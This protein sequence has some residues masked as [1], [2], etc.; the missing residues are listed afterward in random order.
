MHSTNNKQFGVPVS[1]LLHSENK[2]ANNK[3]KTYETQCSLLKHSS[4]ELFKTGNLQKL[5]NR[6]FLDC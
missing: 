6:L 3:A 5:K 4:Y 1:P 2:K